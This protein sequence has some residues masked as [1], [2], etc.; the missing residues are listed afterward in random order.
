[1]S[2]LDAIDFFFDRISNVYSWPLWMRRTFLL[3]LPVSA[4]IWL[5]VATAGFT[6]LMAVGLLYAFARPFLRSLRQLWSKP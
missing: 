3:T 1:M 5:L 2:R 4:P 6:G